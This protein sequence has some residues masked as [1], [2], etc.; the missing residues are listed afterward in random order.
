MT[1]L[2]KL[3]HF[4]FLSVWSGIFNCPLTKILIIIHLCIV[5]RMFNVPAVIVP[6]T[7]GIP[8]K[9]TQLLRWHLALLWY[10]TRTNS[11]DVA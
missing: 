5:F 11:P 2:C 3:D 7:F 6:M 1:C 8:K 9:L 4:L 10:P